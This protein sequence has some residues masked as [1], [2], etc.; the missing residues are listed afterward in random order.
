MEAL[1]IFLIT[2][3]ANVISELIGKWLNSKERDN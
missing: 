1:T 2:V 3:M